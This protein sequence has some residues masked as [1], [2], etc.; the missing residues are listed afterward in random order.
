M[1]DTVIRDNRSSGIRLDSSGSETVATIDRTRLEHN[2]SGLYMTGMRGR[3]TI[4]D[5]VASG[6]LYEGL[7]SFVFTPSAKI[8]LNIEN[9]LIANNGLGCGGVGNGVTSTAD[10]ESS[11]VV[12]ISHSTVIGNADV[13][14][15][16]IPTSTGTAVILS[17]GDNT[18]EG[19]CPDVAGTIGSFTPR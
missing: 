18:V 2:G 8:E 9:C 10:A 16:V 19:N 3:A 6:N 1:T 14:L 4:R 12:R 5:S 13:G 11:S 15:R 7:A 17:R